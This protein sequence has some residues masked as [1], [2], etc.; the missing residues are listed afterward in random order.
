MGKKI[1]DDYDKF[2]GTKIN[3]NGSSFTV[4]GVYTTGSDLLDA[5]V[6]LPIDDARGITDFP[7]GKISYLNVQFTNPSEDQRVVE[8]I[9]LIYGDEINARSLNDFSSQFGSIF[10]SVTLL[11]LLIASIA[12]VVA[13]V[14]IINTMLMSVLERFKEIGALK[15]VGWT[16]GNIVKMVLYESAFIGILGGL[17]GIICGY[18]ASFAISLFGLTTVVSSSLIIGSF[19]GAVVIGIIGGMYPAFIASRMDPV[20]ALRT[21]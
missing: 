10:D 4:I 17:M 19:V 12:S 7:V 20:E 11:V 6:L 5:S 16:R 2:L 14:G 13:A 18:A 8:R 3:L 21:E 15:A 1:K 9:N